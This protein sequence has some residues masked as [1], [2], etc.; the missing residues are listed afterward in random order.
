LLIASALGVATWRQ[1]AHWRDSRALWDR[2]LSIDP[3]NY[4]A[5]YKRG[6]ARFDAGELD[7]AIADYR[8]A[9]AVD[10]EGASAWFHLGD[11]ERTRR[12][13]AA[14]LAAYD[15]ALARR[16]DEPV[17]LA[18]RGAFLAETG[19]PARGLPDLDRALAL[20]PGDVL[21]RTNRANARWLLGD[22]RGTIE[23]A[24]RVLREAPQNWAPR[25]A[26]ER[27]LQKARERAS[28][29]GG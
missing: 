6:K 13:D 10:A 4:V 23:D 9:I 17:F 21:T 12:N 3:A 16:P 19:D 2:V 24:E 26:L 28:A 7:G 1:C 11:A 29:G 5:L 15:A 14:A 27:M 18:R 22:A 8:A 25:A 20:A